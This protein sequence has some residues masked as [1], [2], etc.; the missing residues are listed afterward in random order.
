MYHQIISAVGFDSGN[1]AL[2]FVTA[3]NYR[4]ELKSVSIHADSYTAET[5]LPAIVNRLAKNGFLTA[6]DKAKIMRLYNSMTGRNMYYVL[7]KMHQMRLSAQDDEQRILSGLL[8][9]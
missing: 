3:L 5:T 4:D 1:E 9:K 7:D 2:D 8:N 6:Q